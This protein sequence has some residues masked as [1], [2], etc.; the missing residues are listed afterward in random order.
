MVDAANPAPSPEPATL[1]ANPLPEP[2]TTGSSEPGTPVV[3]TK[4]EGEPK[5]ASAPEPKP[6][7]YAKERMQERIDK[8]TAQNKANLEEIARLKAGQSADA[9]KI[10]TEIAEKAEKLAN[11]KAAQIAAWNAFNTSLNEAVAEGQKEFGAEKFDKNVKALAG[12]NDPK[13]P[14]TNRKYLDMLQATLDTGAA[15]KVLAALG[16]DPNEASRIM[17]LTPTKMGV[18][19]AK[20]AF[21]DVEDVSKAPKPITP[22]SGVGRNHVAIAAEDPERSDGLDM[23][24]WMERRSKHVGEVNS[25]AGR[26]IIP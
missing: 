16:E 19:L 14:E 4:S 13:D 5:P 22:I 24:V 21:R 11:E 10:Q 3:E 2:K 8:I 23:R 15:P 25:R 20:L 18:E 6:R 26:R 17:G 1:G 9:T 12:L 7:D